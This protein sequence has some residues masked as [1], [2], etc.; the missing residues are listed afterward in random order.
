MLNT[1]NKIWNATLYLRLSRDDGDKEE[2]NSITGQRELLRDYISQRPELREYAV[3]VDDGFSGSTFERPSFQKMIE[4]VKAG[5][6]DCIIVKDLSRFG[7]NYLDAGEY[8]EKIFPFLGVRFIAVNDNYDSLGDKK[9]SDDLIIPFKNL[10]NEAYCRDISVKIR[11]QLEIKRKSGQFLGSFAAFGYLKDEQNKNKLVVDQYAADIVRDIFKWKLEG[12]SPQDIAVALNKLGVLSPMEYKRSLGMKFTTSFK[13]NAKA[14]WSAGTV[15]RVLKNPIYTGVLVQGKE[16]TPS[17]KVHK[18][19]TKDKDEW[20][21]IE[22]SHEAI[23][24]KIDFD[25]VQKVLK[26]DTRRSPGGKA[27]GLF[28]GMIFCG[29]CG[30][31]MVRKTVP[32]G[33]KKYVYYICSAHKQDKSCSPHRIRDNALE[34]IVLDSLKQHISEV[35]DMSELLTITD[36]APLRTAQA[37]KVQRQLDKKHEEYEKLQ[38]LLMSLYENLADGIIDREEYT[39]LKASFTARADEAEKQMDALREQ[40]EDIH[41]H[42]T[43][44]AWMNEFIKRQGLTTLDRA[45]VVALIDK[46]LIHSNDVVEIIYRWQD[47]FAWQLDILRS[48]RLREV[49]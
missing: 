10:I 17:Y 24:S 18:R 43:E 49:V 12:I 28:S 1:Q 27:V 25:S 20:T 36:T 40:L 26:C 7:R 44:N 8:I 15:I 9:A 32:A 41:N 38:K 6:T 11:S 19:V 23:I 37:Q 31:S 42:G 47:E 48:A 5:R 22:D 13:T 35:V 3:R 2:S 39:R 29:D 4:D 30:A 16:T 46:I 14:V 21:V 45:V 33:E 34:E